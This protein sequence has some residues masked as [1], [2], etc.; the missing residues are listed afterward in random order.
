MARFLENQRKMK[1][2]AA[3]LSLTLYFFL[4]CDF[5]SIVHSSSDGNYEDGGQ[6][7]AWLVQSIP[8][9]MPHLSRVPGV[10]STGL[11]T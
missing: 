10:L 7:K 9:D 8:T 11:I 6:C 2:F 4:I 3:P 1:T 5:T